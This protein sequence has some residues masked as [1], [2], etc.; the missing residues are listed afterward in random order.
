MQPEE[1]IDDPVTVIT[2]E[3]I[4]QYHGDTDYLNASSLADYLRCPSL[5]NARR[6]GLV[7]QEKSRSLNLGSLIHDALEIGPE[8]TAERLELIPEE[9]VTASGAMSTKKASKDW[10]AEQPED[11]FLCTAA[12]AD[13]I[14]Q[15][16][17]HLFRNKAARELYDSLEHKE[18]S[19]R[20]SYLGR[21]LRCRPDGITD[22]G[23]LVDYKTTRHAN[24]LKMFWKSVDEYYYHVSHALYLLGAEYAGFSTAPMRYVVIGTTRPT[25]H[26]MT[27]PQE[28]IDSGRRTLDRALAEIEL[29]EATEDWTPEGYG[30]VHEMK[31]PGWFKKEME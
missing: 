20:F 5:F 8:A 21:K 4:D 19:I 26:V 13:F 3:P 24:P 15:V 6:R 30:E 31:F 28:V 17:D 29:R 16:F 1:S 9:H 2:G 18:V 27:L 12:D 14:G 22:T 11:A 7:E 23:T 25:V 10:L